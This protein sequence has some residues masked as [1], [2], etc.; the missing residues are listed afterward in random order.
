MGSVHRLSTPEPT[1]E[2]KLDRIVPVVLGWCTRLGG[3]R[4]DADAAASDAL[5]IL[6]RKLPELREGAALEPLAWKVVVRTVQKH[7][8]GAWWRRWLPGPGPET[9]TSDGG[10]RRERSAVVHRLLGDLGTEH[11]EVLVLMDLEERAASEVAALLDLPEGTV[12][13]RLRLARRAFRMAAEAAGIN[14]E[15]M[16]EELADV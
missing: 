10:D 12:R 6:F 13:S 7:R 4:I 5:L 9:G 1:A 8:R 3:G 15:L 2:Q 14:L 11:R 16:V